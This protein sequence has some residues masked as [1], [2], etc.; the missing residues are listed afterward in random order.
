M[1]NTPPKRRLRNKRERTFAQEAQII[2]LD[3]LKVAPLP[4]KKTRSERSATT[5]KIMTRSVKKSSDGSCSQDGNRTSA[6]NPPEFAEI[7][8][9]DRKMSDESAQRHARELK[10]ASGLTVYSGFDDCPSDNL[11]L[12]FTK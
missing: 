9:K 4:K 8:K 5:C 11:L 10:E 7:V 1:K 6:G 2:S 12:G 3:D